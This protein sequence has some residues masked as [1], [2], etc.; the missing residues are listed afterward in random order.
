ML[1]LAILLGAGLLCL[2]TIHFYVTGSVKAKICA[3]GQCHADYILVLGCKVQPDGQPTP[4]LRDRLLQ[5][6]RLYQTGAAPKLLL[7]GNCREVDIMLPFVLSAG[8][9]AEAVSL[10]REGKTTFESI[11]RAPTGSF[12]LVTQTYHL[13]RALFIANRLGRSAQGV[14]ADL[15]TYTHWFSR[16]V[17]EW[18]AQ[19]KAFLM[20]LFV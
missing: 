2:L 20:C 12:L 5:A 11:R 10:D 16:N 4:M 15:D 7:S 3:P 1:P 13:Y 17:R 9:P 19:L 8:V 18:L 6:V 14:A